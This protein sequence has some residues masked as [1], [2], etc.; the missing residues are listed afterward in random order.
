[1]ASPKELKELVRI[2]LDQGWRVEQLRSGHWRFLPPDRKL[3]PVVSAG[4][5][6][7]WRGLK[8]LRAD[9]KRRGLRLE[10]LGNYGGLVSGLFNR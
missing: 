2:A 6:S 8:N 10:G 7:D 5:P 9:L 4:T 3:S 1:M